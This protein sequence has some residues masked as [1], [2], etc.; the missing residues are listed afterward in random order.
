M[1]KSKTNC[2]IHYITSSKSLPFQY[3]H[4]GQYRDIM[5]KELFRKITAGKSFIKESDA[6]IEQVGH[7]RYVGGR[8]D[9]IG[10]LQFDFLVKQGLKPDD[11]F[12]DVAC[13]SLR[14]G[15]HFI[16]YLG[17]GNYLGIEKE[18]TLVDL[19]LE[20]ELGADLA[21]AKSPEFVIS[22]SF[23]FNNFSK[24]A[25]FGIAQSLFTHLPPELIELCFRNLREKFD[26]SGSFFATYFFSKVEIDNG[27]NSHDHGKFFYTREQVTAFGES[28]GW[29]V[30]I[31]GDWNHPR[32][33]QI[34][35]YTPKK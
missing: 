3:N 26:D 25:N 12:V 7:R 30:E 11:V 14:A 4:S 2:C 32:D 35:K 10:K 17:S 29:D 18:T 24:N 1:K 8:W 9:E 20:K 23:E 33:Q 21:E 19:G 5:L 27:K 16:P 15:I 28:T 13:G 31:I 34:V 22:D 6:G